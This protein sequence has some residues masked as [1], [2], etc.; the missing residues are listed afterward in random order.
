MVDIKKIQIT[1]KKLDYVNLL[2]EFTLCIAQYLDL[3]TMTF[4]E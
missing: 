1:S 3:S 4:K 2:E